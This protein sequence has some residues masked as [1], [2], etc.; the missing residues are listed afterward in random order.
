VYQSH[1]VKFR[2]KVIVC[3]RAAFVMLSRETGRVRPVEA[4][5][6]VKGSDEPN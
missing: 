2:D 6:S 5:R 4:V 1:D 3:S